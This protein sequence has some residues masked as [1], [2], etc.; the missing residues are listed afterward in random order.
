VGEVAAAAGAKHLVVSHYGPAGLPD[1]QW[2]DAIRKN[3]SGTV[4]IAR[5]GQVFPL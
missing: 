5:D 3:Y 4:T 1:F 2:E